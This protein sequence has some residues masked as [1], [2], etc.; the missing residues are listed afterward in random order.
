METDAGAT[1]SNDAGMDESFSGANIESNE[2]QIEGADDAPIEINKV[3]WFG[4]HIL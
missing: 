2:A 3:S 1:K 4:G